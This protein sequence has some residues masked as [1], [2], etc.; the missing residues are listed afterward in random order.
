M[1]FK[2]RWTGPE[3]DGQQNFP[4]RTDEAE[5]N[6]RPPADPASKQLAKAYLILRKN[7]RKVFYSSFQDEAWKCR[8]SYLFRNLPA[9]FPKMR[10]FLPSC[11]RTEGSHE[12]LALK[13]DARL[14]IEADPVL[15]AVRAARM[16]IGA[17]DM[18]ILATFSA[19]SINS[20]AG[21]TFPQGPIL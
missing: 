4:R 19:V 11:P 8:S 5:I 15:M 7:L 18:M 14:D 16:A 1:D 2:Q 20:S 21:T 12:S 17:F 3:A 6:N 10:S 9:V 13:C